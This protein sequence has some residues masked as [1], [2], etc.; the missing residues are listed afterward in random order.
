MGHRWRNGRHKYV[1]LF[2]SRSLHLRERD[3][4]PPLVTGL[5]SPLCTTG[6]GNV[7]PGEIEGPALESQFWLSQAWHTSFL[8]CF[9]PARK[10]LGLLSA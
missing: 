8:P 5:Q 1:P 7:Y 2:L 4:L 9:L 10:F 3:S 6:T